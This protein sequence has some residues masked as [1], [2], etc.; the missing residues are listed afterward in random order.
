MKIEIPFRSVELREP[1]LRKRPETLNPVDMHPISLRKLIRSMIHPEVLVVSDIH[2][3]A[4]P[5]PAVGVDDTFDADFSLYDGL[6]RLPFAIRDDF[7]VYP[8][9]PFEDPE[10]RLFDGAPASFQFPVESSNPPPSEIRFIQL[11]LT[12]KLLELIHLIPVYRQAEIQVPVVDR[13]P[14][15]GKKFVSLGG[16]QVETET[17]DYFFNSVLR[18]F[19][20]FKHTSRL[21]HLPMMV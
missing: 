13:L 10:H 4:V 6:K 9:I 16:S 7:S 5:A 15:E 18:Y 8:S 12:H 2:E 11:D 14:I 1:P 3:S 19:R 21:N 20:L 17:P